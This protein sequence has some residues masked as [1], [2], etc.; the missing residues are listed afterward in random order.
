MDPPEVQ[1]DEELY[2]NYQYTKKFGPTHVLDE[3]QLEIAERWEAIVRKTENAVEADDAYTR[4]AH[5]CN[6]C[7]SQ[8]LLNDSDA[9]ELIKLRCCNCGES[10]Q[11]HYEFHDN[12]GHALI[13]DHKTKTKRHQ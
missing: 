12:G 2:E 6:E 10:Y 1:T 9:P 8:L 4:S 5:S 3:L 7:G 11:G 13:I